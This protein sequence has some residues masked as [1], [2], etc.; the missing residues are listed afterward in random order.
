[1]K[2]A[3]PAAA[4]EFDLLRAK[5]EA[6]QQQGKVQG[7]GNTLP[8]A[9]TPT[10]HRRFYASSSEARESKVRRFSSFA[11]FASPINPFSRRDRSGMP[12]S[13]NQ[14]V[15]PDARQQPPT[16]R[17]L[18]PPLPAPRPNR[19]PP[20]WRAPGR[21]PRSQ[22]TSNIPLL[23]SSAVKPSPSKPQPRKASAIRQP[24]HSTNNLL[25]S[26]PPTPHR[27][28]DEPLP[29]SFTHSSSTNNLQS[30]LPAPTTPK[31]P[32]RAGA[33]NVFAAMT[34]TAKTKTPR[35]YTQPNLPSAAQL[36]TPR[37]TV[38]RE[39][40]ATKTPKYMAGENSKPLFSPASKPTVSKHNLFGSDNDFEIID[41]HDTEELRQYGIGTMQ[42]V[43]DVSTP[44]TVKPRKLSIAPARHTSQLPRMHS[45]NS[46]PQQNYLTPL[47]P[48]FPQT[49]RHTTAHSQS[50]PLPGSG[51]SASRPNILRHSQLSP[52]LEYDYPHSAAT[53][54]I[55]RAVHASL[56]NLGLAGARTSP[57]P[58]LSPTLSFSTDSPSP[59]PSPSPRH[60]APHTVSTAQA[61]AYW[62]GRFTALFDRLRLDAFH[63][64][65][66]AFRLTGRVSDTFGAFV[67]G[68]EEAR[69]RRVF[70]ELA[71]YCLTEEATR[72]L[73]DFQREYATRSGMAACMPAATVIVLGGSGPSDGGDEGLRGGEGKGRRAGM[74][75]MER[76]RGIARDARK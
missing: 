23:A 38:F 10:Q 22:T 47:S 24:S 8:P 59:P 18:P 37:K 68:G 20:E 75:F 49:P 43:G 56:Q 48:P 52:C 26:R 36:S 31:H 61:P 46:V 50:L 28:A 42:H 9:T 54:Y 60:M 66:R 39:E 16:S 4:R 67:Q 6:Q 17:M 55:P 27:S 65:G 30:K 41:D 45:M 53:R 21:L 7:K 3:K 13:S 25:R 72:S 1:M 33:S 76:L 11:A 40:F 57:T 34:M 32:K 70:S 5:W 69:A 73:R 35:S 58:T 71:A 19:Q 15:A 14:L 74:G 44:T 12:L 62:A 29:I 63:N 51:A 64:E 2:M